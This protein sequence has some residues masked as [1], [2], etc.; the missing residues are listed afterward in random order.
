MRFIFLEPQSGFK[1][2]KG[3]GFNV[4]NLDQVRII[5]DARP[6]HCILHFDKDHKLTVAGKA[7]NQIVDIITR[8]AKADAPAQGNPHNT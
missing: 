8:A 4:I 1:N 7:A 2:V 6:D 5:T 3:S